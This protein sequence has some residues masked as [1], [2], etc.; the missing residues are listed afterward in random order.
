M[1]SSGGC[2]PACLTS[3]EGWA[4]DEKHILRGPG[5]WGGGPEN[6]SPVL[7]FCRG[8]GELTPQSN[9]QWGR[10]SFAGSNKLSKKI[11]Q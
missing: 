5:G 6:C 3:S 2:P 7:N 4:D 1:G 9:H 11:G 10:K 8:T